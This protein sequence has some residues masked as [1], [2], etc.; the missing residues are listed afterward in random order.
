MTQVV[1][2][3]K[4]AGDVREVSERACF[5]LGKVSLKHAIGMLIRGVARELEWVEGEYV[6]PYRKVTAVELVNELVTILLYERTG[7]VMFS[8]TNVLRRD[9]YRCAYCGRTGRTI[10]HVLPRAQGGKTTW[11]NCVAA[12]LKC[13]GDKADRTPEQAGMRLEIEPWVPTMEDLGLVRSTRR[14]VWA[15]A[16]A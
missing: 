4:G 16:V 14:Y 3:N 12:C 10:D 2:Y 9:H 15:D 6:G 8:K 11:L 1:I 5:A 7:R 13:N